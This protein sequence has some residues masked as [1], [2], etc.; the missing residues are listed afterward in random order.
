M[1]LPGD[2]SPLSLHNLHVCLVL[3]FWF[4]VCF[5]RYSV[6]I[7]LSADI[8]LEDHFPSLFLSLCLSVRLR[9]VF[10]RKHTVGSCFAIHPATLSLDQ[11]HSFTL[12]WLFANEDLVL[13][14]NLLFSGSSISPL[15]LFPHVSA[16][17]FGLGVFHNF[18]FL[19]F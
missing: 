3:P 5:V 10:W 2:L 14:F 12:G 18:F 4:K 6:V 17:H 9:W 15:L 8:Y 16:W 1:C 11:C 13:R 19:S 7:P